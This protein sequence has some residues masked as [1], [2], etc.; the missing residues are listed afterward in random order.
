MFTLNSVLLLKN[1]LNT[2]IRQASIPDATVKANGLDADYGTSP[3][4]PEVIGV[5]KLSSVVVV[6]ISMRMEKH[7][8]IYEIDYRI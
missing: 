4:L 6:V 2:V 5:A 3:R 8:Q 1:I 7:L